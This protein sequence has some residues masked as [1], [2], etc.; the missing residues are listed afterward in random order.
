[1]VVPGALGVQ[2]HRRRNPLE[3]RHL[4]ACAESG[5]GA[6]VP[7]LPVNQ[8]N[9]GGKRF[10]GDIRIFGTDALIRLVVDRRSSDGSGVVHAIAAE[11]TV[12]IVNQAQRFTSI[13][14][15]HQC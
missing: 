15:P 8:L 12:A 13:A 10:L 7:R 4:R 3:K 5:L 2:R 9:G 1:M 11:A 6:L 14:D